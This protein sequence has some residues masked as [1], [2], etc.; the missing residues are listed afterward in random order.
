MKAESRDR[1]SGNRYRRSPERGPRKCWTCG[2]LD[3][4]PKECENELPQKLKANNENK[5]GQSGNERRLTHWGEDRPG[6]RMSQEEK[7]K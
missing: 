2:A 6:A 1:S 7:R 4:L 3:H 5:D